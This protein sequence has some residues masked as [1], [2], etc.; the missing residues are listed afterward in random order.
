MTIT[1][2]P[3]ENIDTDSNII[4]TIKTIRCCNKKR[5]DENAIVDFLYDSYPDCNVTTTG[6]RIIY[7][8]NKNK[9]LN[10][11][12]NGKNSYYYLID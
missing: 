12:Q 6:Q 2:S 5:F 10:I 9:I 11:P 1:Y 3:I 8:E 4:D 7:L